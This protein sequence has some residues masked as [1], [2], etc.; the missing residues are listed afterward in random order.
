MEGPQKN[1]QGY[2]QEDKK[3]IG[4]L[5][6]TNL[7]EQILKAIA[8]HCIFGGMGITTET[9]EANKQIYEEASVVNQRL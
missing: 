3:F 8:A 9:K 4:V 7:D 5:V 1:I 6:G 2:D